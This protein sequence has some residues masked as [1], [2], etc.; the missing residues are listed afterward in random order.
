MLYSVQIRKCVCS[1][2]S[3]VATQHGQ[4]SKPQKSVWSTVKPPKRVA[5]L[6]GLHTQLLSLAVRKQGEGLEGFIM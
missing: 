6:L 1:Q 5:S 3:T 2:R 4:W